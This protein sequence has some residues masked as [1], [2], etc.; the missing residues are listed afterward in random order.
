M[1]ALR[2]SRREFLRLAASAA[3][4]PALARTARA[5]SYPAR[6]VRIIIGF[7]A[8]TS[9]DIFARLIGQWLSEHLGQPFVIE[10]RP[11]AGGNVGTEAVV[12]AAPDGYTLLLAGSPNAVNATLYANLSFNFI[13]DIV[14]IASLVRGVGVME[15]S[16]AFPARTVPEFIAYAKGNPGKINMGS[17]GIGT[18]QHLYGE[19]F[20]AMTGVKLLHVP[21]R[22]SPAAM[23]GLFAGEVQVIFDT[24]STAIGQI[25]ADKLRALAVTAATRSEQLPEVPTIGEFVPG[26][27]A[28]SWQ[29]ICA[30]RGTPAEI[31][32]A[33]NREI[34]AGLADPQLKTRV[35][36]LG[37]WVSAGTPAEFTQFIA[38][39][40]QKW[41]KVIRDAN[42]KAE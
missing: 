37:Y 13:R 33:L 17:S 14:P 3:A 10:N 5:Q 27:E 2:T 21:Y 42:I 12:R 11:G 31:V 24:L 29:G 23:A 25:R 40:T 20:Q 32:A 19:M 8:G 15:V 35:A 36:E 6:P 22:G 41:S 30:P 26:Y 28:T 4:L 1:E 18:P 38:D 7:A 34:N 16:P 9:P 39:D